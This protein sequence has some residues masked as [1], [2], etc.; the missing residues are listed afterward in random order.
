MG[1]FGH[2]STKMRYNLAVEQATS[3]KVGFK[4]KLANFQILVGLGAE[5]SGYEHEKIKLA[6]NFNFNVNQFKPFL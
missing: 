3:I 4:M 5:I 6:G 2:F 1:I